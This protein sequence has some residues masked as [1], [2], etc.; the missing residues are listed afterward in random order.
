MAT[1]TIWEVTTIE[2]EVKRDAHI[3]NFLFDPMWKITFSVQNASLGL[4]ILSLKSTIG[5]R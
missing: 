4:F 2:F 3:I 5:Y 1:R